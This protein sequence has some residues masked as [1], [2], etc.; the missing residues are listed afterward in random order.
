MW[1][2]L[3]TPIAYVVK[4]NNN[5]TLSRK[6]QHFI[7]IVNEEKNLTHSKGACHYIIMFPL[8]RSCN[9]VEN[10]TF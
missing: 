10:H 6:S 4:I 2:K 8:Q 5:T 1:S 7:S 9:F 3:I